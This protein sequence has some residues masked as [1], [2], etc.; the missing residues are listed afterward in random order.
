ML[1][2]HSPTYVNM[3]ENTVPPPVCDGCRTGEM[4]NVWAAGLETR[5]AEPCRTIQP[6]PSKDRYDYC[7]EQYKQRYPTRAAAVEARLRE[8][9]LDKTRSK[10]S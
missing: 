5:A 4:T 6:P 10:D 2:T 7:W 1:N 8:I 3:K 9:W